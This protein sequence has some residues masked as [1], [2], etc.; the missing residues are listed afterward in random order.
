MQSGLTPM[1]HAHRAELDGLF[2][3]VG[4]PAALANGNAGWSAEVQSAEVRMTDAT[5]SGTMK[6]TVNYFGFRDGLKEDAKYHQADRKSV[7]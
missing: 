1:L 7:V 5:V 4:S 3:F 6:A 2:A